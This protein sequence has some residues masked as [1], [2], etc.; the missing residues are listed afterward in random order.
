MKT[1]LKFKLFLVTAFL[2]ISFVT[3]TAQKYYVAENGNDNNPGTEAEPWKTLKKVSNFSFAT[4][5]DVYLK[6]GDKFH[7]NLLYI[8]WS[9]TPNNPAII[10]AYGSGDK[11]IVSFD[12]PAKKNHYGITARSQK[13]IVFEHIDLINTGIA[14]TGAGS[15]DYTVRNVKVTNSRGAAIFLQQVDGYLVEDC[16]TDRAG[17]GGIAVWGSVAPL[18]KNGIIRNNHTHHGKSN[19]GIVIHQDGS[20]GGVGPNHL[21]LN[22]ISHH[23]PEQGY[24]F[25]AGSYIYL[26]DNVSYDNPGGGITIGHSGHHVFVDKHS[27]RGEGDWTFSIGMG[28][29]ISEYLTV[30]RSLL[31]N[32]TTYGIRL[33][34]NTKH[35]AIA[36][37]T[38]VYGGTLKQNRPMIAMQGGFT[39]VT[40]KNNILISTNN[41]PDYY[42]GYL[43]GRNPSNTNSDFDY[44]FYYRPDL[45]QKLFAGKVFSDWQS[46]FNQD[47]HGQYIDPLLNNLS[48]KDYTLKNNS[49]A[50]D[51]GVPLT[52]T[53]NSGSGTKVKVG[54][55]Y[56]FFDGFGL[57][58]GDEISIGNNAPVKVLKVDYENNTLTIDK[59]ISWSSGDGVSLPYNGSAPDIGAFE[60]G[61]TLATSEFDNAIDVLVYPNPTENEINLQFSKSIKVETVSIHDMLG[62]EVFTKNI[63]SSETNLVLKLNLAKGIYFVKIATEKGQLSKK[64]IIE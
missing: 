4:G 62:K 3:V 2:S 36:N 44:N 33:Q 5:D 7:E 42:I 58:D 30:R 37:N 11:P 47:V 27:S 45:E 9:G 64:I 17:N 19:D 21:I 26:R 51:A 38:I 48:A 29:D 52:N 18:A 10:G 15:K 49:P 43:N 60:S 8:K 6:R 20:G 1:R 59:S 23:N 50:I 53:I 46:A 61:S 31:V 24:D 25:T 32:P 13:H 41:T 39:D 34:G 35:A 56:F 28:G 57:M 54:I 12:A 16:E 55:A 14:L 22:N 40:V 63:T